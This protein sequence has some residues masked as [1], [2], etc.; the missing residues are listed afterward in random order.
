MNKVMIIVSL[1]VLDSCTLTIEPQKR[2]KILDKVPIENGYCD[3]YWFD[4]YKIRK[5]TIKCESCFIGQK[6]GE[7]GIKL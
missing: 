7:D 2:Y 1:I 3:I 4:E 6:I 5:N